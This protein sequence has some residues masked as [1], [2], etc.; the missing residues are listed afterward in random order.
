MSLLLESWA[1][2]GAKAEPKKGTCVLV[3][4]QGEFR[5]TEGSNRDELMR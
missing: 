3:S 1:W 4:G 2:G 5:L